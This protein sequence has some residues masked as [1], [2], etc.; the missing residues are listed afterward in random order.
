VLGGVGTLGGI[1]LESEPLRSRF[2]SVSSQDFGVNWR[3]LQLR[4]IRFTLIYVSSLGRTAEHSLAAKHIWLPQKSRDWLVYLICCLTSSVARVLNGKMFRWW[5]G[6]DSDESLMVWRYYS[7]FFIR[8]QGKPRKLCV[9]PA[10]LPSIEP[11]TLPVTKSTDL[12]CITVGLYL[13]K[14]LLF[15]LYPCNWNS[16]VKWLKN[17]SSYFRAAF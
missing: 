11:R 5:T 15:R 1:G 14:M 4:R 3:R 16:I 17:I 10:F 2:S 12:H 9:L 13:I 6:M 7:F 8:N